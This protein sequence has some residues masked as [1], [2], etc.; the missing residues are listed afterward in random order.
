[1]IIARGDKDTE[2]VEANSDQ[3]QWPFVLMGMDDARANGEG[4][5]RSHAFSFL[6]RESFYQ[7]HGC[8]P[9]RTNAVSL[10]PGS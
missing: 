5:R 7:R 4:E 1:V 10:T 6:P 8:P 3:V 9:C 2:F